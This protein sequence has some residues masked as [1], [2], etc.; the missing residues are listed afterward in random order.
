MAVSDKLSGFITAPPKGWI[1]TAAFICVSLF[2]NV[3]SAVLQALTA[4][5]ALSL[6][7]LTVSIILAVVGL[8][9]LSRIRPKRAELIVLSTPDMHPVKHPGIIV[10]V[11]PGKQTDPDKQPDPT[12]TAAWTSIEYH[13]KLNDG[14]PNL[15]VCWLVTSPGA[16]GGLPYANQ[17]KQKLEQV[18]VTTDIRL[19]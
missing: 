4:N 7:L 1:G 19:A 14:R 17:L 2:T 6:G 13:L 15:R 16:E 12:K 11:G 18:G 8:F 10:L 5:S 9:L 3:L